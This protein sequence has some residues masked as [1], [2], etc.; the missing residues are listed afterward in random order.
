MRWLSF[1]QIYI[2]R[3][4]FLNPSASQTETWWSHVRVRCMTAPYLRA[5]TKLP[6][7]LER[8]FAQEGVEQLSRYDFCSAT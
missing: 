2:Q 8:H 4:T 7:V 5:T 6:K 1:Y 3:H